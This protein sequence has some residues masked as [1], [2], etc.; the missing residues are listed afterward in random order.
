M[1]LTVGGDSETNGLDLAGTLAGAGSM[2]LGGS[3]SWTR[4]SIDTSFEVASGAT[5]NITGT[6]TK[7]INA[8]GQVINNG[9]VDQSGTTLWLSTGMTSI[10]NNGT[11]LFTNPSPSVAQ[12]TLRSGSS[13]KAHP[14][15]AGPV[16]GD[17]HRHRRRRWQPL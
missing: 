13:V 1:R 8:A 2:T 9:T 17:R 14:Q 16:H 3:G 5:L 4:G 7:I 10:V 6:T 15:E 12:N 11:W